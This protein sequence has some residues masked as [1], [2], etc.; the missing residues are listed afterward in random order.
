MELDHLQTF[1]DAAQTLNFSET[2]QRLHT[3]QPTVSKHIKELEGE[4][5][6]ELFERISGRKLK[7][8]QQG[9]ALLPWA[10]QLLRECNRFHELAHSLNDRITGTLSIACATA[11]G[12]YL[13]PLLA[14][15]FRQRFPE[16]RLFLKPCSPRQI[17]AD[18]LNK[19]ADL[20]IVSFENVAEGLSCQQFFVDEVVLIVPARHPWAK[21]YII[22]PDDLLAEPI[23]LREPESGTRRAL[24]SA[25]A[26]HDISISDLNVLLELG[27][28]EGIVNTVSTGIGVAFVPRVTA[29]TAMRAGIVSEV[30]VNGVHIERKICML[31][32][33]LVP[34]SR[35][36][37]LF[38]GFVHDP[39]NVD[40]LK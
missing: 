37:E 19:E 2:A 28:A 9:R 14:A 6:V 16:V 13:L 33:S 3:S 38:W 31:R 32:N 26:A 1:A 25:L 29:K 10:Q 22:D 21:R 5:G 36:A 4:L 17:S 34:L 12:K 20:G 23:L 15:R 18:L 40:I 7:L 35:P 8:S 27:N 30:Q 11:S 39:E 24:A